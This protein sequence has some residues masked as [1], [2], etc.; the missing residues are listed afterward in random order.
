MGGNALKNCETKRFISADFKVLEQQ[1][2]G[3]LSTKFPE[4]KLSSLISYR[5]KPD[6]GDLDI[7]FEYYG[8]EDVPFSPTTLKDIFNSKE[9]VY[10]GKHGDPRSPP[11]LAGG[12][13]FSFEFNQLQVDLIPTLSEEFDTSSTYFAYNDLG[14][15]MGRIAHKMGFKYGHKGLVYQFRTMED[16]VTSEIVVSTDASKVFALMGYDFS[17]W[18]KGFDKIEDV[19]E[20][21]TSSKYFNKDIYLHHNRNHVSR[22]RDKKRKNYN[23]FLEWCKD[24]TFENNY[25]WPSMEERGGRKDVEEFMTEAFIQFSEFRTKFI[26]EHDRLERIAVY[27]SNL[28]GEVI[29]EATGLRGVELGNFMDALRA[30]GDSS[31]VKDLISMIEVLDHASVIPEFILKQFE[32]FKQKKE[33]VQHGQAEEPVNSGV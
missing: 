31:P 7:L 10:N 20:F 11:D 18:E 17:R 27:K 19:F 24:K 6:F 4:R 32:I 33:K 21:V 30:L 9:V 25:P 16:H 8:R 23:L 12:K 13:V 26:L 22:T 28:N 14:N 3:I 2:M 29:M 15:L 1:V 5:S